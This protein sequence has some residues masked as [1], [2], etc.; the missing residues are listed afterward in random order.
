[1]EWRSSSLM[2]VLKIV[3]ESGALNAA[4]LFAYTMTIVNGTEGLETMAEL[5]N[6]FCLSCA[7]LL[8]NCLQATPLIGIIFSIVI[9][10]VG[11]NAEGEANWT[12]RPGTLNFAPRQK[13]GVTVSSDHHTTQTMAISVERSTDREDSDLGLEMG[14]L[15]KEKPMRI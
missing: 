3:L 1:M 5:V 15:A 11:V 8:S 13:S 9:I 7:D 12:T 14:R 6:D 10:R 4:Y 2:P